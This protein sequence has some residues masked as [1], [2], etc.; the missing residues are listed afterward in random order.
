MKP[1]CEH[2]V[3]TGIGFA[4]IVVGEPCSRHRTKSLC[5]QTASTAYLGLRTCIEET[6]VSFLEPSLQ[7]C[8]VSLSCEDGL[9]TST[10]VRHT[11]FGFAAVLMP[12]PARSIACN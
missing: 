5:Y 12:V 2:V 7:D 11:A 1:Y 4:Q 6:I 10:T 9:P 8:V 3:H